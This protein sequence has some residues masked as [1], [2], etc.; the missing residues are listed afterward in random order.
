MKLSKDDPQRAAEWTQAVEGAMDPPR[1]TLQLCGTLIDTIDGLAATTNRWLASDLAVAAVL[2]VA[3]AAPRRGMSGRI[4]RNST[5]P[6][7]WT[8][9]V[10]RS[11]ADRR[12]AGSS[13]RS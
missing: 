7:G 10:R 9:C 5:M 3:A 1:R 12:R 6:P 2:L 8:R 13:R 4:S 11:S